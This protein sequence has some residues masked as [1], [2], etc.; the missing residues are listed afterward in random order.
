VFDIVDSLT[1]L[2]KEIGGRFDKGEIFLMHLVAAGTAA[3]KALTDVL[4]PEIS[5]S[6]MKRKT[7]GKVVIGTV[8]GDIHDIGKSIVAAMLFTAGFEVFDLGV[9]I[10]VEEFVKKVQE[11]NADIIALSALLSTTLPVQRELI[12]ALKTANI[13]ERV[14]VMVGGAPATM[15]WA[16]S[17]GADGYGGDAVEAVKVAKKLMCTT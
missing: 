13:R 15:E 12:Q 9:D 16:E 17:I 4:E 5:R 10:P 14:K 1:L 7:L 6:G 11:T 3:K 2:L 8:A